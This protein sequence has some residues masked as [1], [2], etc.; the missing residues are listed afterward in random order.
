VSASLESTLPKMGLELD[1]AQLAQLEK[2][3][4]LL[5]KWNKTY[6]LVS[7]P[8]LHQLEGRHLLDS[9]AILPFLNGTRVLDIGTGAGLPG[10]PLAIAAPDKHF[11]LLDSNGK[12]TRFLFQVKLAL[13]LDNITIEN[14]RIEHYQSQQQ[15]DIVTCR[16]FATIPEILRLTEP[17]FHPETVL[18]AMKGRYP[19][20]E[21]ASLPDRSRLLASHKL[22]I[23]GQDSE[24]HL[25]A[26]TFPPDQ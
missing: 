14:C 11:V 8:D 2:Y 17:L 21:L 4:Q 26:I 25:L 13:G 20:D 19:E 24:R 10:I 5:R 23:P 7:T 3:A 9:L 16:A 18:L 22:E 1:V 6:N 12:K 15:I